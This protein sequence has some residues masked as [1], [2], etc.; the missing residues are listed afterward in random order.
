MPTYDKESTFLR[1]WDLLPPERRRL[2]MDAVA[3]MVHDLQSGQGFRAGLRVKG[4]KGHEGIFEMTW[5]PD[6]RATFSFGTSPQ[7]GDVHIIWRRI[8][9]HEIFQNP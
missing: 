2:F 5:A 7:P 9:G 4:V 3:K 6:G 1:D 8:G